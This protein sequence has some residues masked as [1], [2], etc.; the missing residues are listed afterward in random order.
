LHDLVSRLIN[1]DEAARLQNGIHRKIF[2]ANNECRT[3]ADVLASL[4]GFRAEGFG[5]RLSTSPCL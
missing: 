5:I 3:I 1:L 2:G 4:F